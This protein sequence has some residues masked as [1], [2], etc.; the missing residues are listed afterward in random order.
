MLTRKSTR[1]AGLLAFAALVGCRPVSYWPPAVTSAR[2]IL[3]LPATQSDLRGIGLGDEDLRL[4]AEQFP[5]LDYLYLNSDSTISDAGVA[6][7]GRAEKLR[8]VVITNGSRLSDAGVHTLAS[9]PGLRELIIEVAPNLTD[10]SL[11]V[12]ADK[13]Q[14]RIVQLIRCPGLN[15]PAKA[16]LREV[17]PRCEIHFSNDEAAK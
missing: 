16:H 12:L 3:A 4:I 1:L 6:H 17:L 7:L 11:S 8:Q 15:E 10:A 14:L 9:L 2:D 5:D 13:K